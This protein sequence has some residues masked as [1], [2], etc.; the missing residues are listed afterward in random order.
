MKTVIE[1]S[2]PGRVVTGVIFADGTRVTTGTEKCQCDK[3]KLCE[4]PCWQRIGI[5]SE[6]CCPGCPPLPEPC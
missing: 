1:G 3:G 5:T 6:P 2:Y 4:W